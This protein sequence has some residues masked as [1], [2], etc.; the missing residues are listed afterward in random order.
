VRRF[1]PVMDGPY[2]LICCTVPAALARSCVLLAIL[3]AAAAGLLK[4]A[5][6]TKHRH[7]RNHAQAAWA[8]ATPPCILHTSQPERNFFVG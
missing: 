3:A 7:Q 6:Y 4:N 8:T 2:R 5:Q 1:V